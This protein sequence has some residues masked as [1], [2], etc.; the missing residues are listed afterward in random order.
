[1]L[2][3][4]LMSFYHLHS[5]R[6]RTRSLPCPGSRWA[7]QA[8]FST[9]QRLLLQRFS[10][11]R[12]RQRQL[13]HRSRTP[14]RVDHSGAPSSCSDILLERLHRAYENCCA[15]NLQLPHQRTPLAIFKIDCSAGLRYHRAQH[16]T[17]NI[18]YKPLLIR[19][20][21]LSSFSVYAWGHFAS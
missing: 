16:L 15:H 17:Q 19:S 21:R 9:R 3:W 2:Y 11:P 20:R 5:R 13:I 10:R 12:Q 8:Q 6:R 18:L 7:H 14:P 1:M 4:V